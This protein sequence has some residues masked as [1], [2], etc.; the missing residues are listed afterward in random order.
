MLST[1]AFTGKMNLDTPPERLPQGD[2]LDALNIER[3]GSTE[4]MVGGLRGT[5]LVA[6]ALPAGTNEVIG[7]GADEVRG[8]LYYAVQN[9]GGNHSLLYYD[10]GTDAIVK[11][12]ESKTDSGGEDVL[13]FSTDFPILSFDIIYRDADG[14]LLFWTDGL[15]APSVINVERAVAGEY[16]VIQREY[17][18]VALALPATPPTVAYEHDA[19]VKVNNLRKKLFKFR[20][21]REFLD[22]EKSCW[23]SHS[24][25]PLPLD[26]T[27]SATDPDPTK[28]ARIAVT[29]E[30]GGANVRKIEVAACESRGSV[31]S[32]FFRIATIDK[33]DAGLAD[34]TTYTLYFYND[35]A[36]AYIDGKES[37]LE[38][39]YVPHTARTQSLLN[40][41]VL[42]YGALDEGYDW[43]KVLGTVVATNVAAVGYPQAFNFLSRYQVSRVYFDEKGRT[44]G[45]RYA[46]GMRVETLAYD[47]GY[48]PTLAVSI[49]DRP[50]LWARTFQLLLTKNLSKSKWLY[51]VSDQTF[52]DTEFAYVSIENLNTF[53]KHNPTSPL[54]YDFAPGDR[55]RFVK[56]LSGTAGLLTDKDYEIKAQL[57]APEIAGQVREGQFLKIALPTT[58]ASFDFGSGDYFNYLVELYT[59]AQS[60]EGGLDVSYE[61]GEKW[62]VLNPG[63]E[64]RCHQGETNQATD[65][66]T[67]ALFTLTEGDA[68]YRSRTI[69]T[70][71]ELDYQVVSG[72]GLDHD[73]GRCTVGLSYV[74]SSYTDPHITAKSIATDNLVGFDWLSDARAFLK[75]NATAPTAYNFKLKGTLTIQFMDDFPAD[76]LYEFY[77]RFND[78]SVKSV[79]APFD[80]RTAGV[81]SFPIDVPFTLTPNSWV[82][83]M[84]WSLA[85]LDHSRVF[86]QT[87]LTVT[88]ELP[89]TVSVIDPNFSDYFPSAVNA[90]GRP[91]VEDRNARRA[92]YP[93]LV[94]FGDEFAES[95]GINKVNR[96]Y[97][98]NQ[99]TYDRGLGDI[100]KLFLRGRTLYVFQRL[101]IGVVPILT[102]VWRDLSGN[103]TTAQSDK[104]LNA[105]QYP[106]AGRHGVGDFA[107]SHA[108]GGL[109]QYFANH[110]GEICRLSQDGV[111]VLSDLYECSQFFRERLLAGARLTGAFLPAK[112]KYYISGEATADYPAFTV[113]F[114]DSRGADQGFESK[115]SFT[116]EALA[117]L[118]D[119]L[120]SLKGGALWVHDSSDYNTFYGVQYASSITACFN[121]APGIKKTFLSLQEVAP[122]V[123]HCPLIYTDTVSYGSQRQESSIIATD[124]SLEENGYFSELLRD[125]HS[126]LGLIDGEV[127]KGR[128]LAVKFQKDGSSEAWL[129]TASVYFVESPLNPR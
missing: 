8:R 41:N 17:M 85:N 56:K 76:T 63:T 112:K 12:L 2:Y 81:R 7:R 68:Y 14:D 24:K 104:L 49:T 37:L 77:L 84:G 16:G 38:F 43:E 116:P 125:V 115:L 48:I 55:I 89:Y 18:D 46:S 97:S 98:D 34:D 65:L 71:V 114:L 127:L 99:D 26:Y 4:K 121:D 73:A 10:R 74:G 82:F 9:S 80:S 61:I 110:R 42:L 59:P 105:I 11:V 25:L 52:K 118:I 100:E 1:R 31:W 70:G 123:W 107:S 53:R 19:T 36:Y 108:A 94:R 44:D 15:N 75:L 124:F 87:D 78:G 119:T 27:D 32:D 129:N 57:A 91:W 79:V 113:S 3:D 64:T 95:T 60:V 92:Y 111:T 33:A 62:D 5:R 67:P 69:N 126:P 6:Y 51:W 20:Y 54:S 13:N 103:P 96:F 106:Y 83:L 72:V 90:Y 86:I 88:R 58:G 101:D 122:Y 47:Q 66:S 117:V 50:P 28:N 40:G 45:A 35:E 21:R 120:I 93:T 30:T 128:Y 39:D 23:S 102:Q 22:G 109:A 29:I